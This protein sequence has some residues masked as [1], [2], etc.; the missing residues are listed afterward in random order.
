[1]TSV[2]KGENI[3]RDSGT[4]KY[5]T[6]AEKL[7]Y[8]MGS[9]SHNVVMVNGH[10]QMLKGGRFIWYYWT[11]KKQ[12]FWEETAEE[13]IFT[14]EIKA[15]NF[16]NPNASHQRIIKIS[17]EHPEWIV[18]DLVKG[19]KSNDKRQIWHPNHVNLSIKSKYNKLTFDSF[20]SNYYG[21]YTE[22]KSFYFEFNNAIETKITFKK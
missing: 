5:N 6:D 19:L 3:L 22:E 12:A 16:L 9:R 2:T 20:N 11:Q 13:Y 4:Y 1:M 14:G 21:S 8:F 7:N 17:K 10:S 18:K 15:F